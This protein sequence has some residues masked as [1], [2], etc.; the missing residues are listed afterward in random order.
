MKRRFLY[1]AIALSV[2]PLGLISRSL[3]GNADSST[4]LG[5]ITTYLGDTLWAVMFFFIFAAIRLRWK[6]WTLGVLTLTFTLVIE[7]SQLYHGEPLATLRSFTPARFLL[8]TNFLWSDVICLIVGSTLATLIH[9]I[10]SS[11]QSKRSA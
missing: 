5:F 11:K 3:R 10:I 4:P 7:V 1:L 6:S 2:I 9:L 8:G